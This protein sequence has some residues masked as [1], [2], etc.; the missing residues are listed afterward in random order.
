MISD[1]EKA[2]LAD[3]VM[4][5]IE[6]DSSNSSYII[7]PDELQETYGISREDADAVLDEVLRYEEI[8]DG[9]IGDDGELD[10]VIGYGYCHYSYEPFNGDEEQYIAERDKTES[11]IRKRLSFRTRT[12]TDGRCFLES[13][14]CGKVVEREEVDSRRGE[15][16][17]AKAMLSSRRIVVNEMNGQYASI[18][19]EYEK[20]MQKGVSSERKRKH[21]MEH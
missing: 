2:Y 5:Q 13:L 10:C 6:N 15:Q 3:L 19:K 12:G 20:K 8:L 9:Y 18:R 1:S 4:L 21:E 16:V 11:D 14:Y 7:Y 17:I